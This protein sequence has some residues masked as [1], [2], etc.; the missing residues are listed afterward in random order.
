MMLIQCIFNQSK[1]DQLNKHQKKHYTYLNSNPNIKYGG[2]ILNKDNKYDSILY[3][4]ANVSLEEA[5]LIVKN[6]PY[7]ENYSHFNIE[8]FI[9][10]ISR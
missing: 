1:L 3:T 2:V 10:K 7:F 4:I 5:S 8:S 9:E 6:D